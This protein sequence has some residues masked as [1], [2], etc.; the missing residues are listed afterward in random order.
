MADRLKLILDEIEKDAALQEERILSDAETRAAGILS[1]AEKEADAAAA[2][3]LN[4]AK[5]RADREIAIAKSGAEALRKKAL[6]AEKSRVVKEAIRDFAAS[7]SGLPDEEYFAFFLRRIEKLPDGGEI[8]F[9]EKETRRDRA[10]FARMLKET[11]EK[12]GR[13]YPLSDETAPEI[14][15][16]FLVRYGRIEENLSLEAVFAEKEDEMK[17]RLAAVLFKDAE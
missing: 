8:V 16:G 10:L 1:D 2:E 14:A 7:L 6:L 13:K 15:S 5:A 3:T 9:A 11:E 12:C 17:D 4:E